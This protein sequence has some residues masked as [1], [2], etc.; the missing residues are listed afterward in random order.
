MELIRGSMLLRP[1]SEKHAGGY[2]GRFVRRTVTPFHRCVTGNSFFFEESSRARR[3]CVRP[4]ENV[5]A[6]HIFGAR[7]FPNFSEFQ[8]PLT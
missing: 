7:F 6:G 3:E 4:I 1:Q 8:P 2:Q 5:P